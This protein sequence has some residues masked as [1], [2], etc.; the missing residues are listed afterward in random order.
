MP[1]S[2]LTIVGLDKEGRGQAQAGQCAWLCLRMQL[3][4]SFHFDIFVRKAF[5]SSSYIQQN[6]SFILERTK[7]SRFGI[8]WHDWRH[9]LVDGHCVLIVLELGFFLGK[10]LSAAYNSWAAMKSLV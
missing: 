1:V 3:C 7:Q 6:R 10:T 4:I 2:T 5:K 9:L 8:F